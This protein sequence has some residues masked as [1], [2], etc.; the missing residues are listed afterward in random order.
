MENFA[1]ELVDI[2]SKYYNQRSNELKVLDL[3]KGYNPNWFQHQKEVGYVFYVDRFAKTINGIEEHIEYLKNLG[4]TYIHLMSLLQSREGEND[5]GFAITDYNNVRHD[6]GTLDDLE[7][8]CTKLRREEIVVCVDIVLNHCSDDHEW[9]KKA[10]AGHPYY[11]DY[12][13]MYDTKEIPNE[14]EKTLPEVFPDFKPGNFTFDEKSKRWVWTTF[15]NFQLAFSQSILVTM[16]NFQTDH[17]KAY[18]VAYKVL[19]NGESLDW[20]L[21]FKGGSFLFKDSKELEKLLLLKGISYQKISVDETIA[22]LNEVNKD[23]YNTAS[24]KLEKAPKIGVYVPPDNLPWDDAVTLAMTYAEIPY[25]KI[26]D[27]EVLDGKLSNY[28]WLH[29]HHEDFTGQYGKF[30]GAFR[31]ETWYLNQVRNA[32]SFARKLGFNKVSEEKKAVAKEIRDFVSKGGFMFAMCSAP[33]SYDIALAAENIDIVPKEIDGDGITD[34]AQIKLNFSKTFAFENFKLETNPY[35]YSK[36]DVDISPLITN[37]SDG[38]ESDFFTLFEFSAKYDPVPTMLTQ[39]HKAVIQGF[40]GQTTSFRKSK[41]KE[42]VVVMGEKKGTEEVKYI[43]GLFGKGQFCFYGGHDP[44]DYQHFVGEEPTNLSL[45]KNSPGYRLILNKVL[46]PAAE[47]KK[48]K[49]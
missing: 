3:E 37:S 45:H 27:A 24:M 13:Y 2:L 18:G 42:N 8:L 19:E 38:K 46:F 12:F 29:V 26:W 22:L 10:Q 14:Y 49:T 40:Y 25:E 1:F 5:G 31:N 39:N 43:H 23:G 36:S 9:A 15:N 48:Q 34:G 41:L 28:D 4:I 20:L 30:F 11:Q 6:L 33:D 7:R 47:K 16:D 32:E 44:E 35:I 21:N 17:L